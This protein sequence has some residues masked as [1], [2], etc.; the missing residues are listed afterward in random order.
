MLCFGILS[1]KGSGFSRGYKPALIHLPVAVFIKVPGHGE[2]LF[3][4]HFAIGVAIGSHKK[5]FKAVHV[6]RGFHK[7]RVA[8]FPAFG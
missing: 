8:G 2:S 3:R 1:N 6:P 5:A 7:T 4:R